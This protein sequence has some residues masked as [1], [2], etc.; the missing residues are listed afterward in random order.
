VPKQNCWEFKKC[1]REVGGVKEKEFGTCPAT[2]TREL[3]GTH[4]GKNAGR[5]CWVVSGTM[6]GGSVQ[7]TFAKKYDTCEKCDF[8]LLV[9]QEE[10]GKY[11]YAPGLLSKIRKP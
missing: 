7:G 8:Y 6:C 5:A 3:D 1:G 9:R 4:S 2:I 11:K 10:G